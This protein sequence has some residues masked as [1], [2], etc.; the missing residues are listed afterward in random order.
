MEPGAEGVAV[1]VEELRRSLDLSRSH[2]E[3]HSASIADLQ[4][5]E[6]V[7]ADRYARLSDD[8]NGMGKKV[9][10]L[11]REMDKRLDDQQRQIAKFDAAAAER[12]SE[13]RLRR[14]WIALAV[15]STIAVAAFIGERVL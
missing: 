6:A 14:W 9:N 13:R 2:T 10:E 12:E 8:V 15:P 1:Q 3:Q 4:R 7:A 5:R 11:R